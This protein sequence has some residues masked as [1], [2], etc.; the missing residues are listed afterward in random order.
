MKLP[1]PERAIVEIDKIA[2]YCLNP[3]HPEGKHKARVFK[4]ALDLDLNNAEE[5]EV[6][7]LQAVANY[8]A[9][10]GKSNPYGQKYIIDFPMT[11]SDKQAII[12]SVWIVRNNEGFPRLVTCYVI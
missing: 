1:N 5:L 10:P 2:G 3:E 7:L 9:I 6:A 11:R 8:D 4:S 12:Q